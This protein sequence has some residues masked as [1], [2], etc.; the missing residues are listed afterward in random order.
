MS[1][2]DLPVEKVTVYPS[3]CTITRVSKVEGQAGLNVVRLGPIKTTIEEDSINVSGQ[4][5]KKFII[6]GVDVTRELQKED[7]PTEEMEKIKQE[8][9]RLE[10]KREQ[11]VAQLDTLEEQRNLV[12]VITHKLGGEFPLEFSKGK[13]DGEKLLKLLSVL[14][15]ND[16]EWLR[17]LLSTKKLLDNL[18]DE[19]EV[20]RDKLRFYSSTQGTEFFVFVEV[21]LELAEASLVVL[22]LRYNSPNASWYPTYDLRLLEDQSLVLEYHGLV[23][24]STGENW[25]GVNLSLSTARPLQVTAVPELDPQWLSLYEPPMAPVYATRAYD[26]PMAP[27]M[28]LLDE[29]EAPE[30]MVEEKVAESYDF[31]GDVEQTN[32][33][34]SELTEAVMFNVPTPQALM[35]HDDPKKILMVQTELSFHRYYKV[36]P[37]VTT[38]V[39][40]QAEVTNTSD[41]LLLP[42]LAR[43]YSGSEFVGSTQME[44]RA[45]TETFTLTL[46][47]VDTISVKRKLKDKKLEKKGTI[48]K[49]QKESYTYEIVCQS[50]RQSESD[51]RIID[52][53][54]VSNS[55]EVKVEI[56]DQN[57][58]TYKQSDLHILEW[59]LN[60]KPKEKKTILFGFRVEYPSGKRMVGLE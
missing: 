36:V 10:G 51:L 21:T 32:V 38:E 24:Q 33:D 25:D 47:L 35:S 1:A 7:P 60:L 12:K 54:P 8:L 44:K 17:K 30:P 5:Q 29:L 15:E 6:K 11:V 40:Q 59:R 34:F 58:E 42:G 26:A 45:P 48:S 31:D 13:T 41:V 56:L 28:A 4:A 18:D 39:Y 3:G 2:K 37:K 23:S 53:L 22:R 9:E 20:L 19:I 49:S 52:Q 50:N 43:I 55:S 57:P 46:G 16:K 14:A 27:P